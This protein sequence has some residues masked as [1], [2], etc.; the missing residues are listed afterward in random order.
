MRTGAD[1]AVPSKERALPDASSA[2]Q[3]LALG[4]ETAVRPRPPVSTRVGADHVVPS[5]VRTFPYASV[6][7]QNDGVGH[8]VDVRPPAFG[9]MTVDG[10]HSM[11]VLVLTTAAAEWLSSE[12]RANRA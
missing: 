9:S 7:A 8:D 12:S 6:A 1:H 11:A 10:S 2:A 5:K 4:Q 3:N